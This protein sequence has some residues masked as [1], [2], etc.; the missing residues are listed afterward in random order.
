MTADTPQAGDVFVRTYRLPEGEHDLPT[1]DVILV[2]RADPD[3]MV[4]WQE[5]SFYTRAL[6]KWI[7]LYDVPGRMLRNLTGLNGIPLSKTAEGTPGDW[8]DALA[9][10][11][12]AMSDYAAAVF[13]EARE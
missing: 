7:I 4:V 12:D 3:G 5:I 9:D 1:R 10:W 13:K 2:T 6:P 8:Y 11:Y